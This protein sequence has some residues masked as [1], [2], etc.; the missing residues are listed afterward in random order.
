MPSQTVHFKV[1]TV[2]A[3]GVH[4]VD[5]DDDEAAAAEHDDQP[6]HAEEETA[7]ADPV[8]EAKGEGGEDVD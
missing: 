3:T 8:V 1:Q 6:E 7:E 5:L 4:Q 2:A